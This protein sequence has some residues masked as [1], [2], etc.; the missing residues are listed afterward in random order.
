MLVVKDK[1]ISNQVI[2]QSFD[3]RTLQYLHEKY[4]DIRTALLIEDNDARSLA[5]QLQQLGFIPTIY[6][7][8]FN[9]VTPLLVKQCKEMGMLLIPWTIND[10]PTLQQLKNM[11]VNGIISDYPNLFAQLK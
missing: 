8:A 3:P 4:P 6:S 7:P 10:L 5:V 11:G 1:Q 9:L 2:I